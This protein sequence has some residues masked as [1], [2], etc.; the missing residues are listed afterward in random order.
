M[1]IKLYNSFGD[2]N[3]LCSMK[4]VSSEIFSSLLRNDLPPPNEMKY[5]TK[6]QWKILK[7]KDIYVLLN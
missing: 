4:E 1:K 6:E 2:V 5:I 7:K 3:T